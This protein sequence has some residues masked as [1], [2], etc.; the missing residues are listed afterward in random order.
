MTWLNILYMIIGLIT[1]L[2][3]AVLPL[4]IKL[5]NSV[6]KYKTAKAEA[7]EAKTEAEQKAAEAEAEKAYNNMLA[8]AQSL[9]EAAEVAFDGY[10]KVMK[11]QGSTAG[12]MKKNDVSSKLQVFALSHGYPYD[13]EFWS[14]KIDEIVKF[15]RSVNANAQNANAKV[16]ATASVAH[17]SSGLHKY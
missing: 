8:T 12:P 16:N 17:S 3:S 6:K 15:T 4:G 1:A 9:V 2:V 5:Y 11:A 14:G 10:D 13:A 7:A